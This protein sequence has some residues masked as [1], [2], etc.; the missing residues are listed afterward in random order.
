MDTIVIETK[1]KADSKF[2]LEL[3]KKMGTKAKAIN[4]DELEDVPLAG[5]IEKGMKTN[6]V[7]RTSVIKA[8]GR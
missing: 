1:I 5:L 7:S 8:L 2:W 6:N 4:T 3:A